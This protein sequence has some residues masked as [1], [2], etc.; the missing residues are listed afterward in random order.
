MEEWKLVLTKI[1]IGLNVPNSLA[2]LMPSREDAFCQLCCSARPLGC[3]CLRLCSASLM[4]L[5]AAADRSSPESEEP[6]I[7]LTKASMDGYLL[8]GG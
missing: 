6:S 4:M 7:R 1:R 3:C 2:S 8:V 5:S